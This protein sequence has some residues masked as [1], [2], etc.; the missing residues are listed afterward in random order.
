MRLFAC[1]TCSNLVFFENNGCLRCGTALGFDPSSGRMRVPGDGGRRPCSAGDPACNWLVEVEDPE[2]RC[3]SC[4]TTVA[5]PAADGP[6]LGH[7]QGL[8][9]AKRRLL[10]TLLRLGLPLDGMT[11]AFPAEGLTG[12]ADGLITVVLAEA[13]DAERAKRQAELG[14]AYRTLIGHLRHESG[15]HFHSRLVLDSPWIDQVR[16]TFGDEREDYQAALQ[17]HYRDGPRP[18]WETSCISAYASSHPHEDWAETWAHYLHLVDAVEIAAA[19]GLS[20]AP[21]PEHPVSLTNGMPG[22]FDALLAAWYPLTWFANSLNRSI[23]LQDW[24]PFAPSAAVIAKLRLVHDVVRSAAPAYAIS[25]PPAFV[26]GAGNSAASPV[27]SVG[28]AL[29]PA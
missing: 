10:H 7:W 2:A 4:R 25:D 12:H 13:D 27:Q 17:R 26:Q 8:E 5:H 24:Y 19:Y 1:P 28:T 14:E 6:E 16:A 18:G 3:L 22:D 11:F 23:G 20:L 9:R 29:A 21:D 15:H